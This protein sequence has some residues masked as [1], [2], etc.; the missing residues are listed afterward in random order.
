[1]EL[2]Q[3]ALIYFLGSH[4]PRRSYLSPAQGPSREYCHFFFLSTAPPS[5]SGIF[6]L[7]RAFLWPLHSVERHYSPSS[8]AILTVELSCSR[9]IFLT[10][11]SPAHE[12]ALPPKSPADA[13]SP[14][15]K[16]LVSHFQQ[17][18]ILQASCS[19][20]QSA[21]SQLP[22]LSHNFN[23]PLCI[24]FNESTLK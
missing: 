13:T 8:L 14:S 5:S 20:S 9:Y 4:D 21:Y 1:M 7:S 10:S 15:N 24:L 17:S 3:R 12:G 2:H 16:L 11:T 19:S 22:M 18:S 6:S 23:D